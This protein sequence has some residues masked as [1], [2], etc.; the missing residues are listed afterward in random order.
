M[1]LVWARRGIVGRLTKGNVKWMALPMVCPLCEAPIHLTDLIKYIKHH[2]RCIRRM[3]NLISWLVQLL[4]LSRS[5]LVS[6]EHTPFARA[7]I[8][9]INLFASTFPKALS[10]MS[11][12]PVK[13]SPPS[14]QYTHTFNAVSDTNLEQDE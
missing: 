6:A 8:M 13:I 11:I 12:L 14:S 2:Q 10:H 4:T 1:H 7:L 3:G 5:S 9:D